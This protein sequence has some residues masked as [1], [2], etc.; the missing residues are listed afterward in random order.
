MELAVGIF[1]LFVAV[2][3]AIGVVDP[4]KLLALVSRLESRPGLY[5]IAAIRLLFGVALILASD[6]SRAPLFLEIVGAVAL[7][8]GIITPFFGVR[9]M[10]LMLEWWR[11]LDAGVLRIWTCFVVLFGLSLVWAVLPAS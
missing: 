8:S 2:L 1:G 3:G 7:F 4:Q 11:G 9:R 10:G 6:D 5:S